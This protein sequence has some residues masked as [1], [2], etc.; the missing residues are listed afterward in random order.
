M[1]LVVVRFKTLC[2]EILYDSPVFA[3]LAIVTTGFY[4]NVLLRQLPAILL[5]NLFVQNVAVCFLAEVS[6]CAGFTITL[7]DCL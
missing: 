3:T 6:S 7:T 2:P 4:C 5:Q 1:S